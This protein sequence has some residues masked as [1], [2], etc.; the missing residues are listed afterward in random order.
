MIFSD[1]KRTRIEGDPREIYADFAMILEV[2]KRE[3]IITEQEQI[4]IEQT[5]KNDLKEF[6]RRMEEN[7]KFTSNTEFLE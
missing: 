2:F 1:R 4:I 7:D 5:I 3:G 6:E